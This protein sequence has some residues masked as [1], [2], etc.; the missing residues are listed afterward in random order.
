M[1][2]FKLLALKPNASDNIYSELNISYLIKFYKRAKRDLQEIEQ[3]F[4]ISEETRAQVLTPLVSKYAKKEDLRVIFEELSY[5]NKVHEIEIKWYLGL[6]EERIED[7]EFAIDSHL[8]TVKDSIISIKRE[9]LWKRIKSQQESQNPRK[10]ENVVERSKDTIEIIEA[11]LQKDPNL[12]FDKLSYEK[13]LETLY[14]YEMNLLLA[15]KKQP[16]N[17]KQIQTICRMMGSISQ[18]YFVL[19]Q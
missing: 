10:E 7:I 12:K 2:K 18:S 8:D 3:F 19:D 5:V 16:A 1:A 13:K 9:Q 11:K 4:N 17:R 14:E 15:D 6:L